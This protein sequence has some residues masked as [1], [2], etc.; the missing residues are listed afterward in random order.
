LEIKF[1]EKG[2]GTRVTLIHTEIP[3]GQGEMYKQGWN[4]YYFRPMKKYYTDSSR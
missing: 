1:E 3:D 4:D 2:K